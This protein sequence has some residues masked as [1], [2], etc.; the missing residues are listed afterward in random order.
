MSRTSRMLWLCVFASLFMIAVADAQEW[1]A[2]WNR[3]LEAA[4]KEAALTLSIPPGREWRDQVMEFQKR[5]P[6]IKLDA[7]AFNSRD[8]WPRLNKERELG[9]FLWDLRIGGADT[10][11]YNFKKAGNMAPIR[12]LL[13]LPEVVDDAKWS[14]GLDALFIDLDKQ[15][16][17]AFAAYESENVYFN[18][19]AL[20]D[21]EVRNLKNI[22]DAKYQKKISMADP[23]GGA[24]LS[25]LAMMYQE[26]GEDFLRRLMRDSTPVITKD[27]RQ[28]ME[29]MASGRYPIAFG[30]PMPA[31]VDYASRGASIAEYQKIGGPATWSQGFGGLQMPSKGPHPAATKIFVNWIL[32]RDVQTSLM[33]A[34][35]LNG[36][37]NDV[38]P[39]APDRTLR[40]GQVYIGVQTEAF[41]PAMQKAEEVV[42]PYL[43]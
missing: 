36:R 32:T 14:G 10:N 28:Q 41:Q 16:F 33:R 29:W 42:V 12:P 18:A 3:T 15:Y 30:L 9:S 11:V 1:Q 21:P 43:K 4:K 17:A 7:S 24:G 6:E 37:R 13:V 34:T 31:L 5:Y 19:K 23:R 8:F 25:T 38:P 35:R 20:P 27:Y 26:Y 40:A 2:D 22:T 39:G